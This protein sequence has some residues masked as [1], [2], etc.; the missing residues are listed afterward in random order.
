MRDL[1]KEDWMTKKQDYKQS[2]LY[3]PSVLPDM[4]TFITRPTVHCQYQCNI[5]RTFWSIPFRILRACF[6]CAEWWNFTVVITEDLQFHYDLKISLLM[7][8]PLSVTMATLTLYRRVI[9]VTI[10][11]QSLVHSSI[12]T[13]IYLH[14]FI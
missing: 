8:L 9:N 1:L 12:T 5:S 6:M 7:A 14:R 13:K 4:T 2:Y 10:Y 3:P 11:I